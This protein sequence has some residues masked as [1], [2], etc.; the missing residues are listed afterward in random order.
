MKIRVA[1][2]VLNN[3]LGIA[4][5]IAPARATLP[6]LSCVRLT[7]KGSELEVSATDLEVGIKM[8]LPLIECKQDG[9]L[10][11]PAARFAAIVREVRDADFELTSDGPLGLLRTSDGRFKLVGMDPTDFP[12]IPDFEKSRAVGIK[13][14]AIRDM[15]QKTDF[16]V[17]L[18][19]VRYALTGQ[20]LEI[21]G[22]ELR[23]V[24]SDGK[25]L[26]YV[27]QPA[28]VGPN[29]KQIKVIVPTKTTSLL[30]KTL[31]PEDASVGVELTENSI[32]FGTRASVISSR[33]IDGTFPDYEAVIPKAN[34]KKIAVEREAF[35]SA[36]R[37]T[38]LVAQEKA[39]AVKLSFS[40]GKVTLFSRSQEI[41]EASVEVAADYAGEAF[42][43][44]FNPD[45]IIDYLKSLSETQVQMWLRD[46][47]SAGLFRTTDD[48]QY[49]LMPLAIEAL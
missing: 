8:R 15:I 49:V 3:A 1:P 45:Y 33:L 12:Q 4:S 29:A 28:Q 13:A 44:V 48:Y 36:L 43:V 32:R 34:D 27:R 47:T 22:D 35:L 14:E 9:V 38:S 10:V 37:R 24:A 39:R 30:S 11:V 21:R 42:D 40:S 5:S 7:A 46:R 16:A 6:A 41:G 25:R 26:S 2:A 31:T 19:T 20:L 23:M 17:S 18:E